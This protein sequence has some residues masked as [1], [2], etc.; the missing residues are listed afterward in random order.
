MSLA[1]HRTSAAP[2]APSQRIDSVDALR[3]LAL[4]GVLTMNLEIMFRI[5]IFQWFQPFTTDQGLNWIVDGLLEVFFDLKAFA[6]FSLLFG[7][8]LAI[9]YERLADNSRRTVLLVRRL[10]ALLLFGLVHLFL[11]WNGD[12]L[13]E[14]AF[15]GMVVLPF[16]FAPN[17]VLWLGA[18]SSLLLYLV[19]PVL[20]PPMAF[21]DSAWLASHIQAA[22]RVYGSGDFGQILAFRIKE[23]SPLLPLHALVFPR[24]VGLFMLGILL[25]RLGVVRNAK[26]HAR[27]LWHAAAL[28]ITLG[29]ALTLST[30][31]RWFSGWP[32]LGGIDPFAASAATI[33]LS[34]GYCSLAFAVG[35]AGRWLAWFEPLGRMAFTNYI[36]QSLLLGWI[37]YGYG[38]GLFS[39][40]GPAEGMVF[41]V[42]IYAA[43][44]ILSMW[45]L[46]HF[47]HGPL[48]WLW[49]AMMYGKR[50][51]FRV[52]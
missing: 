33:I 13:T 7:V 38:L 49:R 2:I 46:K 24:T 36:V 44:G 28:L 21:Q 32:F 40:I 26:R 41:V 31:A 50:P 10:L 8:G 47:R 23:V 19:T 39:K 6:I 25:W 1:G 9:Q 35:S 51:K 14:Y 15:A 12:I 37:F 3:G 4:F 34:L 42:A 11:I 18:A 16:L 43:Q 45:W 20:L 27:K 22:N 48:E 5:S 17:W 30:T 29:L 52:A